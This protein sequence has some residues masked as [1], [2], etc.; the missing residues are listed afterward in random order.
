MATRQQRDD[1]QAGMQAAPAYHAVLGPDDLL[2]DRPFTDPEETRDDLLVMSRMLALEREVALTWGPDVEG[3]GISEQTTEGR[4]QLLAVPDGRALLRARDV[5][6]VGFFGRLRDAVDHA[7]LFEHERRIAATFPHYAPLGFLSYLDVGPE[8]GRYGNLI[9][10]WTPDVPGEWHSGEA[11]RPR[12]P[13]RR[14]TTSTSV[15]TRAASPARSWAPARSRCCAPSTSTS[16]ASRPGGRCAST[17][18]PATRRLAAPAERLPLRA[19]AVLWKTNSRF[20]GL[21]ARGSRYAAAADTRHTCGP[22]EV[23]AS[24]ER[25]LRSSFRMI[26]PR[27]R[28]R[29]PASPRKK[30]TPHEDPSD[31]TRPRTPAHV[32]LHV[33]AAPRPAAHRRRPQ[34]GRPRRGHLLPAVLA[35]RL[36]RPADGGPRGHLDDHL[37]RAGRLRDRRARPRARRADHRRRVARD[38]H[39]RRGARARRLRGARRGRRRPDARADRRR[40]RAGASWT[41]SPASRSRETERPS[42]TRSAKRAGTSTPCRCRTSR[43][44]RARPSRRAP[45]PS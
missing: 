10:F 38:L 26:A 12:S 11:H 27:P 34:G 1:R 29:D 25:P 21:R 17:P 6:A 44:S 45:R 19:F 4:R 28:A 13:T 20:G 15:S 22:Q 33:P 23:E 41:A 8:H 14:S 18:E 3:P 37:D 32:V 36:G 42:T 43:S 7:V 35:H 2:P 40:W 16:A 9:L 5:T 30:A 31:R 39:G 24:L